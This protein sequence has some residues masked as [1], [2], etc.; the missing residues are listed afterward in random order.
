M[1]PSEYALGRGLTV[2][3]SSICCL[4]AS[5]IIFGVLFIYATTDYLWFSSAQTHANLLEVLILSL[6]SALYL[7]LGIMLNRASG[8][9]EGMVIILYSAI[10][11][12]SMYLAPSKLGVITLTFPAAILGLLGGIVGL[13]EV[14]AF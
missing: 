4:L 8:R 13:W 11:L 9:W 10:L 7:G 5:V 1:S 2:R 12:M 14:R 3:K 6:L